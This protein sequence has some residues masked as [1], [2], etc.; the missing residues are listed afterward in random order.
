LLRTCLRAE[1]ADVAS[2]E[3]LGQDAARALFE[4][5]AGEVLQRLAAATDN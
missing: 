5:G 2:A 3:R 1:V 4:Q